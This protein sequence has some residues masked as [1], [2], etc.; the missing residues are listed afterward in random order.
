[1]MRFDHE[2]AR[3][4][5]LDDYAVGKNYVE[6][7]SRMNKQVQGADAMNDL[8]SPSTD[9]LAQSKDPLPF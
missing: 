7:P 5:N 3:F 4:Q 8:S 9:F 1:N 2:Y 6:R